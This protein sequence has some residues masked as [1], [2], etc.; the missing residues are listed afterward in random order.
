VHA[1]I[2]ESIS[3]LYCMQYTQVLTLVCS[4]KSSVATRMEYL[5]K[6]FGMF[7]NGRCNKKG[8]PHCGQAYNRASC[9]SVLEDLFSLER[10]KLQN[11]SLVQC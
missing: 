5:T 3:K 11:D 6:T 2:N 8:I 9:G 7:F 1:S 4:F 10:T